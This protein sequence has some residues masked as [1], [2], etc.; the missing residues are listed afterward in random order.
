ME[1]KANEIILE[2]VHKIVP[3]P[4]N[5]NIHS[6]EQIDRLC[7]LIDHHG[8]RNPC[9]ISKRSGFLVVGHGRLLAA[10]KLKME[11]VP[12]IYQ[13]FKDEAEEYSYLV[14]DNAIASAI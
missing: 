11:K 2:E 14:S 13:E 12:V 1:I 8:F 7:K 4:K 5:M 9:V 10:Q 6:D 3:N